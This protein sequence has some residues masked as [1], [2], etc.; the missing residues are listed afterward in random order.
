MMMFGNKIVVIIEA[1]STAR[2]D[3]SPFFEDQKRLFVDYI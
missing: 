3:I 2:A 1:F